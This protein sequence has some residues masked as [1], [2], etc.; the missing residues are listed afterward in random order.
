MKIYSYEC[1]MFEDSLNYK[2][3]ITEIKMKRLH[4]HIH[5]IYTPI[6]VCIDTYTFI[7]I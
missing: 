5:K 1:K 3:R 2:S 6:C 4:M 7:Y